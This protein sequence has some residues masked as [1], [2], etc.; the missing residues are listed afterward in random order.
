M[1]K[2]I[3]VGICSATAFLILILDAKTAAAG[4]SDGL[5]QCILS[6]IPV[7]FPFFV[8]SML[9]TGTLGGCRLNLLRPLGKLCRIP[10]GAESLLLTGLL[11]GY[12]VGAGCVSEAFRRGSLSERDAHRML[13]FC[14][15]AGPAFIFGMGM[16]LFPDVKIL[17]CLWAIHIL[18]AV[19]TG[20]LL[21]GSS[22]DTETVYPSAPVDL[23]SAVAKSVRV[24]GTVCGWIILFRVVI[25]F[26]QRWIMWLFPLELQA[27]VCGMLELTNGF[28]ALEKVSDPGLR[29]ILSAGFLGFGGLCV[30]MQTAGVTDSRLGLGMYLPG[31]LLQCSLSLAFASITAKFLFPASSICGFSLAAIFCIPAVILLLFLHFREIHSGN[32]SSVGV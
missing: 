17:F 23:S 4:A 32:L 18:C 21:P 31:K 20:I 29:L 30:C 10:P 22:R 12:P 24:M 5:Q 14:S 8:L 26:L 3:A 19:I 9:I 16:K 28:F 27:F 25:A 7:L 15:N 6:V 11:G 1:K 2:R 13:G